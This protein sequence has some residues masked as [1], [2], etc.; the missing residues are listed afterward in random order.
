M[1]TL[2]ILPLLA[3]PLLAQSAREEDKNEE[4]EVVV[5]L[6]T[7]LLPLVEDEDDRKKVAE[8]LEKLRALLTEDEVVI[9]ATPRFQFEIG[10]ETGA[11]LA[12]TVEVDGKRWSYGLRSLGDGRYELRAERK[13]EDNK[14]LELLEKKGTLGEL[15]RDHPFLRGS[16]MVAVPMTGKRLDLRLVDGGLRVRGDVRL[17]GQKPLVGITVNEPSDTLRH[18]LVDVPFGAGLVVAHVLEGSRAEKLGLR[19]HDILLRLNGELIDSPKQL[20][21]LHETKGTLEILRRGK[22]R[23]IDLATK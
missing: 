19:K 5:Q 17:D 8:I 2:K 9:R 15:M 12:G 11:A 10:G 14:V 23:E 7:E 6:R 4:P 18:H 22:T 20:G 13:A 1:R 3:A 21:G 16:R